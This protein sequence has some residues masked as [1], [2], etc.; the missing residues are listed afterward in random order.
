MVA[1]L[2]PEDEKGRYMGVY[3]IFF[4]FGWSL[5]PTVGGLLYDL[6]HGSPFA[7]WSAVASIAMM[8]VIGFLVLGRSSPETSPRPTGRLRRAKG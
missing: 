8:S 3:G 4:Y 5:G 6:L 1:S 7:L 2:S